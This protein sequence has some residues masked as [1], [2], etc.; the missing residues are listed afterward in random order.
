MN[1]VQ[2]EEEVKHNGQALPGTHRYAGGTAPGTGAG[3]IVVELAPPMAS[4][5][6]GSGARCL[7]A[8]VYFV[9]E[10]RAVPIIS[11][12]FGITIRMYHD[13]HPPPHFHAEYQGY[14]AFVSID[15]GDVIEGRLPRTAAAIVREWCLLHRPALV[16]NWEN[17]QA[18]RPLE[19]IQGADHD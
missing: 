6:P 16:R 12:F 5:S 2:S 11:S 14:E 4:P 9:P 10:P 18:F 15:S 13:D 1:V 3:R 19:R 8:A 7:R 17:A